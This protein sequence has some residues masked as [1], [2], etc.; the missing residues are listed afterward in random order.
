MRTTTPL[1]LLASLLLGTAANAQAPAPPPDPGPTAPAATAVAAKAPAAMALVK[2]M[3]DRLQAARTFTV[4]GRISLELPVAG[5]ALATTYNDFDMSV[6]RPDGLA[7][8]RSGDLPE[9]RFAYDGKAM[10]VHGPGSKTWATTAAPAT[11]DAMLVAAG[12]KGDLDLPFDELLVADPWAA[13]TA[14]VTDAV[15]AGPAVVQGKKVEH[16]VLT[17]AA[18]RLEYWIDPA[19]ALPVRSLVV[20]L[21]HPLQPHFLVEISGWK[22]DQKLP[23]STYALPTPQGATQVDFREAATAYR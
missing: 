11:L 7:A 10:T 23:D 12:E 8:R 22:L 13:I 9:F 1:A 19:S 17:G 2:K 14:G 4:K 6:R 20:Y 5:G 16:V 21:D 18:L 15:V 3:S